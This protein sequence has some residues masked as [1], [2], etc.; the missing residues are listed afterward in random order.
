MSTY[1]ASALQVLAKKTLDV[2]K[3]PISPAHVRAHSDTHRAS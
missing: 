3:Q 2:L 1:S